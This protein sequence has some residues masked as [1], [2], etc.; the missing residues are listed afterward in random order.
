MMKMKELNDED[1]IASYWSYDGA[2]YYIRSDEP[3]LKYQLKSISLQKLE[4]L[5]K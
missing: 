2:I 3:E 5:M 1:K 4:L